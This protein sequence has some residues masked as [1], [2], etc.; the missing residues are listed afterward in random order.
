MADKKK[1]HVVR[2]KDAGPGGP[3]AVEV[4]GIM[5]SVRNDPQELTQEQLKRANERLGDDS[6]LEIVEG[7]RK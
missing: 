2:K 4:D 7:E 6:N 3:T 5:L 1:Y